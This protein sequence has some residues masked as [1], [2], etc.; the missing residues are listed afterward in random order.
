MT[1]GIPNATTHEPDAVIDDTQE[2]TWDIVVKR[3]LD[4][5]SISPDVLGVERLADVAMVHTIYA[6][7]ARMMVAR[8]KMGFEKHGTHLTPNNGR[9]S[10]VDALQEQLDCVVYLQN[11][12]LEE[13]DEHIVK[14]L[15]DSFHMAL[16]LLENLYIT[17][18]ARN[19]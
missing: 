14:L 10:L 6:P 11:A 13:T 12:I 8:D 18:D 5:K 7:L 3:Y 2:P 4:S 19:D 16:L 9:D 17:W 1:H 15:D